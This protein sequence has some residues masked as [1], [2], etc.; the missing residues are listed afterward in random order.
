MPVALHRAIPVRPPR[1][2]WQARRPARG[3]EPEWRRCCDRSFRRRSGLRRPGS[4][5]SRS[6]SRLGPCHAQCFIG[7]TTFGL[8]QGPARL[9]QHLPQQSGQVLERG[10]LLDRRGNVSAHARR[11]TGTHR[12]PGSLHEPGG[13]THGNL[14]GGHTGNH[15]TGRRRATGRARR[16]SLDERRA[17]RGLGG[18]PA[19]GGVARAQAWR[20]NWACAHSWPTVSSGSARSSGAR[21]SGRRRGSTSRRR[22][23][24]SPRWTCASA[25]GR[26]RRS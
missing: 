5:R 14:G 19:A 3:L 22:G 24:R 20:R 21:A 2:P 16:I 13:K 8:G 4:A 18:R 6:S 12:A 23:R 26:R 10:L 17:D 11:A 9:G 15:T 1:R 7:L 25:G